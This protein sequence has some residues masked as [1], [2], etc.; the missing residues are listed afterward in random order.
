MKIE[1]EEVSLYVSAEPGMEGCVEI[2]EKGLEWKNSVGFSS[3]HTAIRDLKKVVS[4]LEDY[5]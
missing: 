5:V 1:F 4:F 3:I 2:G